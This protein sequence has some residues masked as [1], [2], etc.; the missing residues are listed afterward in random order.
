MAC[1]T[2]CQGVTVFDERQLGPV[3][4]LLSR[5]S[6]AVAAVAGP[7]C[8]VA[9]YDLRTPEHTIISRFGRPNPLTGT[10]VTSPTPDAFTPVSGRDLTVNRSETPW[11]GEELTS[12]VWIR[13]FT[14]HAVGALTIRCDY[15]DLTAAQSLLQRL[16]PAGLGDG[17]EH[18]QSAVGGST[19]EVI[20]RLVHD[21][22]H[23]IRKP[24][25]ALDRD[26]RIAIIRTLD[27]AGAFAMRRSAD[28]VA[29]ELAISR[30]S[31]YSYL[32]AARGEVL[33]TPA[34]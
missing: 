33:A 12:T 6:E 21:A 29:H 25:H 5:V 13:D 20:T 15:S 30:A 17:H 4:E 26:D 34:S 14:G 1:N 10:D 7:S 31:V 3:F 22:V 19:E 2:A 28:V 32:R 23:D 11:G 16:L 9:L 24:L 8:E 27:Q 18:E